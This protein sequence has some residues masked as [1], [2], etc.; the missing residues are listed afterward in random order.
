MMQI[1][2]VDA[3]GSTARAC[4][5]ALR[6]Q[7]WSVAVAPCVTDVAGMPD[8]IVFASGRDVAGSLAQAVALRRRPAL[9]Q[10][11]LL[12]VAR[13]DRSGW[14]RSFHTEDAL[15]VDALMDEPV[16]ASALVARLKGLLD[17]RQHVDELK[18]S[19]GFGTILA[20]AIANEG[21][22]ETFYRSAARA[23]ASDETRAELDGLADD[24]RRH[25]QLLLDFAT[26]RRAIPTDK[27]PDGAILDAFG[28]PDLT[29]DLTPSD[30]FLLAA[31]KERL[32]VDLYESWA[33]LYPN[34]PERQLLTGLADTERTHR[35]RV[36][37]MFTNASF[38]EAW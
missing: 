35:D 18:A 29:S 33:R 37:Q 7:D 21:A 17:A 19:P 30:A 14:D 16:D 32:A 25:R 15:G 9:A 1:V 24:E 22:A 12:V 36:E 10:V 27:V 34:G 4:I 31:R 23:V 13:L 38:P 20:Q 2:V 5:R 28:T 8:A 6:A 26:G 3:D 11:P